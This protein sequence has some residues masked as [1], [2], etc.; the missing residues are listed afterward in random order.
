MIVRL[1]ID[2]TD[3]TFSSRSLVWEGDIAIEDKT[4]YIT[5]VSVIG[6]GEPQPLCEIPFAI[7]VGYYIWIPGQHELA[8][9][10]GL[11]MPE[12]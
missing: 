1:T 3:G 12:V 2:A 10:A 6:E 9:A 11:L 5:K 8:D 7:G 4:Q